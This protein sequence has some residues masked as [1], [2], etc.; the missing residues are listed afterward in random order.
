[1]PGITIFGAIHTFISLAAVVAGV[2]SL[3]RHGGIDSAS[4]AGQAYIVLTAASCVTGLF[5][6]H[7]GGFGPP[8][9]LAILTL[10]L[11]AC[12]FALEVKA[13]GS[14]FRRCASTL[15]YS[16]TLFLHSIPGLTE[17]F[18]RLPAGAPW[19]DGPDDPRLAVA[20]GMIFIVF[21]LGATIQLVRLRKTRY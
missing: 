3:A 15:A 11:L 14:I 21:L 6:F 9:A 13:A 10:V 18:T 2:Y 20:I 12:A 1:M 4:R 8:H 17:T 7:H 5:I 19:F 16:A